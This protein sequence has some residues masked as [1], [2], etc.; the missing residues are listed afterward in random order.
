MP[1]ASASRPVAA[2]GA[3]ADPPAKL[4]PTSRGSDAAA[5]QKPRPACP[6]TPEGA[7]APVKAPPAAGVPAPDGL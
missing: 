4:P 7:Q 5:L 2:G 1:P 6:P 3:P